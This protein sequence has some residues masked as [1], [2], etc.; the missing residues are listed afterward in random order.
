MSFADFMAMGGYGAY[1]WGAYLIAAALVM[2]E[3]A[4]VRARL[5]NARRAADSSGEAG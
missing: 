5:R 1:V 4:A 3:V 2:I